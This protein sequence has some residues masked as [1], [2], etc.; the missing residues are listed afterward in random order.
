[1]STGPLLTRNAAARLLGLAPQTIERAERAGT[2]PKPA[3]EGA[4]SV[5]YRRADIEA[6]AGVKGGAR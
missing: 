4:R 5:W 3:L 1:M 6:I 2:F